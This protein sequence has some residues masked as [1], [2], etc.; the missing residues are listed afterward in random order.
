MAGTFRTPL[1]PTSG[2]RPLRRLTGLGFRILVPHEGYDRVGDLRRSVARIG[3]VEDRESRLAAAD[4]L[5]WATDHP[6]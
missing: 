3:S 4:L 5:D 2:A 1:S 6:E